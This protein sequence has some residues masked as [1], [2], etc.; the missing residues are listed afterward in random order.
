MNAHPPAMLQTEYIE[1]VVP[2]GAAARTRYPQAVMN[3]VNR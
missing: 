1:Q 3:T 2:I